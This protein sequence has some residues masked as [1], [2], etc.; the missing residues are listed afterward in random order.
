MMVVLLLL[1]SGILGIFLGAQI[2]EAFLLVPYWKNLKENDFFELHKVYGK[3]IHH[4]FAPLTI[5][6]VFV[7]LITIIVHIFCQT[8][9][10]NLLL[11][12]MGFST[13]AFFLTYF[14]YFRKTNKSFSERSIDNKK[15]QKE[16]IKWGNWH[17]SRIFFE[18]IAFIC[19]L[20]L[21][22]KN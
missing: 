22:M 12:V 18:F 15:L 19:S 10:N 14:L 6:A 4:F 1:S 16:L 7:P 11:G 5:A 3:K 20:L 13:I 17:W 21:L 9:K 8:N 2:A